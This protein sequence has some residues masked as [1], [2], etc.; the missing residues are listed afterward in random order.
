MK[1]ISIRIWGK[2]QTHHIEMEKGYTGNDS[3]KKN[4][5]Y[6]IIMVFKKVVIG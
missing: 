2:E 3:I 5:V 6:P 1:F 4:I